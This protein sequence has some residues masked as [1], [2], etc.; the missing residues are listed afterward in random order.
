MTAKE[1]EMIYSH[2]LKEIKNDR[3]IRIHTLLDSVIK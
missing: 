2:T 1:I 3:F